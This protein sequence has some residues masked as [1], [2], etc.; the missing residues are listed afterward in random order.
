V[1]LRPSSGG[2][3]PFQTFKRQQLDVT[4]AEYLDAVQESLP[5]LNSGMYLAWMRP[6]IFE[7]HI[8]F[9]ILGSS[10]STF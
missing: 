6:R 2:S 8:T 7:A 9:D 4:L 1:N 3:G 5:D 10:P